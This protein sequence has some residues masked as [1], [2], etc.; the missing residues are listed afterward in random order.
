M[1]QTIALSLAIAASFTV[2]A[3]T[4]M[5]M[6]D[7][8]T[9]EAVRSQPGF[10][11]SAERGRAFFGRKWNVTDRMPNCA[12]CHGERPI[13]EGSHVITGKSIRPL[14]PSANAARFSSPAKVEKWFRRNCT[15]VVGRECSAAEKADFV[16]FLTT[17]GGA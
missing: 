17:V 15:E 10:A 4:P 12:A 9:Q 14:A 5:G 11:A 16:Q 3:E 2:H 13:V 1:F 8:Y 7:G 6:I